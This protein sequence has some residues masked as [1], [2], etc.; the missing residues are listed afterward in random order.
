MK[1]GVASLGCAKNLVDTE[2]VLG[3]LTEAGHE[4]THDPR[5][6]EIIIVNTCGF[7]TEAKE[8][9][10]E[11][12]LDMAALKETGSCK[13]LIVMG[14]LSQRY[15]QELW[16]EIPE[17]DA[18]L[19]TNELDLVPAVIERVAAGERVLERRRGYFDYSQPYARLSTTGSHLAYLKIAEGC[20]HH[21][22]FCVIPQIRGRFRSRTVE[23]IL[24]EAALLRK[25]G[26]KELVVI[27]QDSTAY[28]RDVGSSIVELLQQLADLEFPWIR[29]LYT[30][31]TS[32]N[33]ELLQL[34][35]KEPSLVKYVDLPLQHVS[36]RVLRGMKRPGSYQSTLDL[37]NKIRDKVPG[38][39]IRSS[40]IVGFPGE[41]EEDFQQ[42]LQF[43]DQAQLNHVG[44]FKY[45]REENSPAYSYS[46]QVAEAVKER[47]YHEAMS[48]QQE[49]SAALNRRLVGRNLQVLM[50]HP[51]EES[52]LVMVGRHSGQAPEVDGVVYVGRG[53][54]QPGDLV[55]VRIT[56]AQAYDLVGEVVEAS[57]SA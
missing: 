37:I 40:F 26:V 4:L 28:G 10:I 19:G 21:C 20:S 23:S 44:I 15:A 6:A 9:S 5:E 33:D 38:V 48:L 46:G 32:L 14:C 11:V 22:A 36:E 34:M 29:L 52:E 30:Y 25:A 24:G 27:A 51:S 43:L 16:D 2:I 3:F 49:I 7:I 35:A 57:E 47:R 17:I 39:V 56:D 42:L 54:L 13:G 8:E 53:T 55:T 18:M 45:S 50:E 12:I 1:I 41:T 31:P